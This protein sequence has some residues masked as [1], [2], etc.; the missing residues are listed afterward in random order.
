MQTLF[1]DYGA[2]LKH[3]EKT[4]TISNPY[5]LGKEVSEQLR[6]LAVK[7]ELIIVT[8]CQAKR[9]KYKMRKF[10]RS[11]VINNYMKYWLNFFLKKSQ[12]DSR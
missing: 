2:Q 11:L 3:S 5:T 12:H 1:V 7:H 9:K 4:T 8:V 10:I 6:D